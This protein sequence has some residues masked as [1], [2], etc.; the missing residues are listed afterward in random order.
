MRAARKSLCWTA[1]GI[2][3]I[4]AILGSVA[5]AAVPQHFVSQK[6]QIFTPGELTIKRGETVQIVNDDGD[7]LHHL[8]IDS[9]QLEYDSGDQEP[10][11]KVDITFPAK[12][13]F[14]VLCGIHPKMRL[15]VRVD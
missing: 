10:G 14:D 2:L 3:S 15:I 8:Y 9:K 13:A 7:L 4:C 12:G 5:L 6:D 11:A 1:A